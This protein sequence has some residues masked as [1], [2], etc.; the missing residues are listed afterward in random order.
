[1]KLHVSIQIILFII[2]II[3]PQAM[4]IDDSWDDENVEQKLLNR[5]KSN[6]I[7]PHDI[8]SSAY[9]NEPYYDSSIASNCVFNDQVDDRAILIYL[10]HFLRDF[11]AK[12]NI[13]INKI[14]LDTLT[15]LNQTYNAKLLIT[16]Y[17]LALFKKY[18]D[19]DLIQANA[20]QDLLGALM[21]VFV[22]AEEEH[23]IRDADFG[24]FNFY[25]IF[26]LRLG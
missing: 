21:D 7:D 3:L 22:T 5:D 17:Q 2:Q 18:A 19:D 6:W 14:K 10:R 13:D 24:R 11:L 23:V 15:N 9:R 12:L 8:K 25:L 4:T 16:Q 20:L 26:L 1:M